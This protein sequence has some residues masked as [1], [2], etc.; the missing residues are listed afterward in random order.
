MR[1]EGFF[2]AKLACA[3]YRQAMPHKKL[4][5]GLSALVL[6]ALIAAYVWFA[7]VT[8][9][10]ETGFLGQKDIIAH[11]AGMGH[12]PEDTFEAAIRA[13]ELGATMIEM[14]VH[15]T[16]DGYLVTI[17]DTTIDRTTD[18]TGAVAD[19][20]LEELQRFNAGYGFIDDE[21]ERP[22]EYQNIVIP[23]IEDVF[24][25]FAGGRFTLEIKPAQSNIP[26][27]LCAMLKAYDLA[28]T[29]VIVSMYQ[30]PIDAFRAACPDVATA[31]TP[32]EVKSYMIWHAMGLAHWS[33]VK[34]EVIAVPEYFD[35]KPVLS[36][37][38][39]KAAHARGLAVH[40]WTVND[41]ADIKRLYAMGVDGVMTDYID[42]AV[43]VLQ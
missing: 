1:W 33:D 13:D 40:V 35:D 43:D 31:M 4:T 6:I 23:D 36:D 20:T 30:A 5:Y 39:I 8:P 38:L 21:G 16:K 9:I 27:K 22:F 17:H 3:R 28:A 18:G 37:G 29:T 14:D 42:R 25:A 10:A 2:F 24:I 32:D 26:E 34:A 15:E 7:P 41:P 11:R 19:M 12:A